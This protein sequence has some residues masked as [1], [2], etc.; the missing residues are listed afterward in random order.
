MTDLAK[1]IIPKSDQL[2]ADD[3]LT[4]PITI[5]IT[6]VR[7]CD[8][9]D[10]PVAINF[11]GDGG[12]PYKPCKSMRRVLVHCWGADGKTYAGRRA[13]LYRDEGVQFGG[14]K[15]GGIRISHLSHIDR[16]IEMALTVTK[17]RRAPYRI[18]PLRA[19]V[20]QA[21]PPRAAASQPDPDAWD[22]AAWA[23]AMR[24]AADA[25]T[26]AADLQ[27][28]WAGVFASDEFARLRGIDEGEALALQAHTVKCKKA[29]TA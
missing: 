26:D 4:G 27:A 22:H 2:N 21:T 10:Q 8:E 16:E 28:W 24:E 15:V 1:T 5:T 25:I 11:E 13:T 14:I 9:A 19:E 20:R 18:K 29:L 23:Q 6:G 17:A 3:L 7:G 12:K